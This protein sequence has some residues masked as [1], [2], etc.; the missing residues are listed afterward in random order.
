MADIYDYIENRIGR[1]MSFV[2][3][4]IFQVARFTTIS[5][6]SPNGEK[7]QVAGQQTL[8][9]QPVGD[10]V[11]RLGSGGWGIAA[12]PPAGEPALVVRAG[13]GPLNGVIVACGSARYFPAAMAD[14]DTALYCKV[15]TSSV[16]LKASDGSTTIKGTT[17]SVG[18]AATGINLGPAL[19]QP[20]YAT[21]ALDSLGVPVAQAYVS[22][23]KAG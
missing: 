9:E 1:V 6:S 2:D 22:V 3:D 12:V 14:G 7:D 19:Y 21:L 4:R 16:Y 18:S 17:V 13:G 15:N 20:L 23:V 10:D 11:R 8:N 5:K